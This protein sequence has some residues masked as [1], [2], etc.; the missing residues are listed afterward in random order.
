MKKLHTIILIQYNESIL[1]RTYMEFDSI[2]DGMEGIVKLYE[3]RLKEDNRRTQS[4]SYS[5]LELNL[6]I[7]SLFDIVALM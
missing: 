2:H 1:S 3:H 7:D 5:T 6:F 4:I